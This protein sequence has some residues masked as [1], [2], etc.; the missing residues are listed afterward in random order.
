MLYHIDK[1]KEFEHV[2]NL[3]SYSTHCQLFFG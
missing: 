3:V 1:I 2:Y